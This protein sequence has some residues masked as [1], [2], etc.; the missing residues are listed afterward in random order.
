MDILTTKWKSNWKLPYLPQKK[1]KNETTISKEKLPYLPKNNE[2]T[3]LKEKGH[4][5]TAY[6]FYDDW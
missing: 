5:P 2:T 6:V 4:L 3:I 1:I